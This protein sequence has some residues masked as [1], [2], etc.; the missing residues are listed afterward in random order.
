M[1]SGLGCNSIASLDQ[2]VSLGC[3][4]A[5]NRSVRCECGCVYCKAIS[6]T[7]GPCELCVVIPKSNSVYGVMFGRWG[8]CP[9]KSL[10]GGAL[11]VY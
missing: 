4:R 9:Q 3:D 8:D 1:A 2:D 6:S 7:Y 11:Y 10:P 5:W